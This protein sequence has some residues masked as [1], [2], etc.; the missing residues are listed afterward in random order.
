M[1]FP[2]RSQKVVCIY[3]FKPQP[4]EIHPIK[5]EVYTIRDWFPSVYAIGGYAIRLEEIINKPL[6][7]CDGWDEVAFDSRRFR[8]V[9]DISVFTKMLGRKPIFAE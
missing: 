3:D 7:Y 6:E 8:P 1:A 5:D 4:G 2:Y 9:T